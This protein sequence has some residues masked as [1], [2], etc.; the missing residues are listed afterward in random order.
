MDKYTLPK[1]SARQPVAILKTDPQLGLTDAQ[2]AQR[3][4]NGW[5]NQP[6][7]KG[8]RTVWQIFKKNLFT[9]FNLVFVIMAALMLLVG[10]SPLNLTFMVVVAVNTCIGCF[11]EIRAKRAVD[12]LTLVAAQ[13]YKVI[14]DGVP[15]DLPAHRMVRD[16]IVILSPGDP[17]CA[18]GVLAVGQLLVNEALLTGEADPVVKNPGDQ[19]LS[20]SFVV[21]GTGRFRLTQVGNDAFA[22][23]LAAEAK[24]DP[25]TAKSEMMRSLDKLIR[26]IGFALIPVGLLLFFSQLRLPDHTLQTS[27]EVTVAALVGMIPEGLYLLTSIALAVSSLKL[28][29]RR[30]LVQDMN[31]IE[32][33]ARV[34]VLCV[35]KTGTI[36]E[37]AMEVAHTVPLSQDPPEY[38]EAVLTAIYGK[39]QPENNTGRALFE[40][41]RGESDWALTD[42]QPFTSQ[43][44]YSRHT[45][46]GK[47]TFLSGAPEFVMGDGYEAIRAQVED[48]T[49]KGYR[50]LLLARLEDAPVPLA[51]IILTNRIRPEAPVTFA[52]FA[53]QGVTVKV[54]SGDNP[55]A[56]AEVARRAGVEQAHLFVDATTLESWEDILD[57]ADRYTVFGR[58]T[59]EQKRLLVRA[60][61]ELGHTVAMTGDGV[62]DVLAMKEADCGIAMASGAQ[63]AS[64][65]ARLVLLDSDFSAMPGIVNE[66]RRVIN[67]IRRAASLFLVKNIFSMGLTLVTLFTGMQFPLESFHMSIVSSLTIGIPGF[68]LALEPNYERVSGH[69]LSSA[70]RKALP[71]GLTNILVVLVAQAFMVTFDL[72]VNDVQTICTGILCTV[73][74]SVLLWVCL[75]FSRTRGFVW[76]AM[77]LCVTGAFFV[78]PPLTGFLT[79]TESASYLVLLAVLLIVPTV[80]I[81]VNRLFAL[82]DKLVAKFRSRR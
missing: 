20:G 46:E 38:L 64:Q 28:T 68:F 15:V 61:K 34:D 69:F 9:Y 37:P 51:L 81:L 10:S 45:F 43:T 30:V 48:W 75:P 55:A 67:N 54:I 62:N 44:K 27:V 21:A 59:P 47:G 71:G 24:K 78:L 33:L 25:S 14:R 11:Q 79:I 80:F 6:T 2:A 56:A 60:L 23:K 7:K 57:A 17:V 53:R 32:T 58:V 72:P 31:C 76:G 73:G 39:T 63:A 36:T 49:G 19:L 66:G 18:D 8:Q 5:A 74:L 52:Y 70:V 12:R 22:A 41:F 65:V 82:G 40:M 50:V 16:D 35:D 1:R 13:T 3:L 4:T 26:F 42:Y 77:A 29:R